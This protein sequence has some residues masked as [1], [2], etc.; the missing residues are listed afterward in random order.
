MQQAGPALPT[1]AFTVVVAPEGRVRP[2]ARVAGVAALSRLLIEAASAGAAEALVLYARSDALALQ[3]DDDLA[4]SGSVLPVRWAD[5]A[6]FASSA[7]RGP[8]LV[9]TGAAIVKAKALSLL[10]SPGG[11][12]AL[13]VGGALAALRLSDGANLGGGLRTAVDGQRRELG[14]DE[15][16]PLDTPARAGRR[17]LAETVKD[18]DGLVSR[19]LNR[20]ISRAMSH[21]LLKLP[22]VRPIHLTLA[23]LL[24]A[25]I[26]FAV[27]V[28][29]SAP[30]LAIGCLLLQTASVVDGVDGEIARVTFRTS[31]RGA[32]LDNAVDMA[33][34]LMFVLGLT[35]GLARLDGVLYAE[36]GAYA[37]A[38][39]LLG[40][41]A[42]AYLVHRSGGGDGSFDGL[43]TAY[44]RRMPTGVGAAAA[45]ITTIVTSRDFFAFAFAVIGV[46]GLSWTI[47]WLLAVGVTAWLLIIAFGAPMLLADAA[48]ADPRPKAA[49][50]KGFAE[51]VKAGSALGAQ[52]L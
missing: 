25:L 52:E 49:W 9:L 39:L 47:P 41:L 24:I 33:T 22:G 23:T 11:E 29:G 6:N 7:S 40:V 18:S 50:R 1:P 32:V 46:V 2:E 8:V 14:P 13:T 4:R 36:V 51:P 10:A 27:L 19:H 3:L 48:N 35:I 12:P 45:S 43:K 28:L 42:L 34:N 17:L 16:V 44:A 15:A 30:A 21:Q 5:P 38:G 31:L 26:M 37:F 20:P